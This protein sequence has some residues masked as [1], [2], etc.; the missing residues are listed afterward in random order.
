MDWFKTWHGLHHD[1]QLTVVSRR[2]MAK[3]GEALA[4][5]LV[6]MDAAS[7]AKP[8]G[9]VRDVDTTLV[10]TVITEMRGR[11]MIGGDGAIARWHETQDCPSAVRVRAFRARKANG[12]KEKRSVAEQTDQPSLSGDNDDDPDQAQT[13]ARRR[14]RLRRAAMARHESRHAAA[15]VAGPL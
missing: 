11:H 1:P 15:G 10:E 4:I 3:K 14:E 9:F 2:A 12:N 6:L 5:W 13:P 8:R 7:R